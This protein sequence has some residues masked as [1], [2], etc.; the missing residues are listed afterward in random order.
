MWVP[1][2]PFESV[3]G[4][5]GYPDTAAHRLMRTYIFVDG[6]LNRMVSAQI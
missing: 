3:L 4:S 2:A 5:P 1:K 6:T